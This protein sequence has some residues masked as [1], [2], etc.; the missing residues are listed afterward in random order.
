MAGAGHLAI[1]LT[2]N[3]SPSTERPASVRESSYVLGT[4]G[5]SPSS[6]WQAIEADAI[7]VGRTGRHECSG[8]WSHSCL[9]AHSTRLH[10]LWTLKTLKLGATSPARFAGLAT[11][12]RPI[13]VRRGYL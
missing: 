7:P 4:A 10:G 13:S 1:A 5:A 6:G 2:F 3:P 12:S 8:S 9:Q 11:S